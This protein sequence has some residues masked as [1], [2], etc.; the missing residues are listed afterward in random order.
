MLWNNCILEQEK[1]FDIT[2]VRL[3]FLGEIFVD[4]CKFTCIIRLY[5]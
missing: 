5:K 2:S 1:K 4:I 3:L